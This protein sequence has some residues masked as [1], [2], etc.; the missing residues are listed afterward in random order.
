MPHQNR[1]TRYQFG[2][3]CA[4]EK[5]CY[6]KRTDSVS[7]H[8]KPMSNGSFFVSEEIGRIQFRKPNVSTTHFSFKRSLVLLSRPIHPK[9]RS[10]LDSVCH[11]VYVAYMKGHTMVL[12][13]KC[14]HTCLCKNNY[15]IPISVRNWANI[16]DRSIPLHVPNISEERLSQ[17]ASLANNCRHPCRL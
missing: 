6:R 12:P 13:W 7:A 10:T 1:F 17:R 2:G 3:S 8:V 15:P 11:T 9:E 16:L 4:P 5:V 14:I